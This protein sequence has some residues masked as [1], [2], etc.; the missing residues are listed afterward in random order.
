M[1]LTKLLDVQEN[2][3]GVWP[4]SPTPLSHEECTTN[5]MLSSLEMEV[6][7]YDSSSLIKRREETSKTLTPRNVISQKVIKE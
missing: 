5:L 2:L 6:Q 7:S 3:P 1:L 4:V